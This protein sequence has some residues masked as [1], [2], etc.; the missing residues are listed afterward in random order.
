[1]LKKVQVHQKS[2]EVAQK[3]RPNT[4][5]KGR[6]WSHDTVTCSVL[7]IFSYDDDDLFQMER[8]KIF[9]ECEEFF[10]VCSPPQDLATTVKHVEDFI[11]R[12]QADHKPIALITV[13]QGEK[14]AA[15]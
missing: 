8:E 5:G 3:K 10:Q 15:A 6:C 13:C 4:K 12:Q 7:A 11:S 9:I 2:Q 1:M 14:C